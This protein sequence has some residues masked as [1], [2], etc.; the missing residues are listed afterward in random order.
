[1]CHSVIH[2]L[3]I[4]VKYY[5]QNKYV[6]CVK[7]NGLCNGHIQYVRQYW[8]PLVLGN[9]LLYTDFRSQLVERQWTLW[10]CGWI[11]QPAIRSSGFNPQTGHKK[12][13]KKFKMPPS[14][15][16]RIKGYS[17]SLPTSLMPMGCTCTVHEAILYLTQRKQEI[18]K[19]ALVYLWSKIKLIKMLQLAY[20]FFFRQIRH[21]KTIIS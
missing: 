9:P 16:L 10:S 4:W 15:T 5:G 2:I 1:M 20:V 6:C 21:N 12:T 3:G 14:V 17:M 19:I 11:V 18:N 8:W 7:Q 13:I